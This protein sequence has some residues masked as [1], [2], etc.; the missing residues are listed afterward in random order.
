MESISL[1]KMPLVWH[2]LNKLEKNPLLLA[3]AFFKEQCAPEK[4]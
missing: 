1:E 4:E 2:T 3:V